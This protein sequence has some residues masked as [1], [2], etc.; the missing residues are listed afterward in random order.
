MVTEGV[1]TPKKGT[2]VKKH[3]T[4]S[5]SN[6]HSLEEA[7]LPVQI[8]IPLAEVLVNAE[9]AFFELCVQVGTQALEAMM[10][11]DRDAVCGPKGKHNPSRSALRSGSAPSEITLGGRRIGIRRLRARGSDGEISLPSFGHAAHRDPLDRHTMEAVAAGVSTR[12]YANTLEPLP[13]KTKER[14][15]SK[16][17]VSRRFIAL[18]QKKLAELLDVSLDGLDIRVIQIDGIAFRDHMVLIALGVDSSGNKQ[19][20]GIREGTTESSGVVHALL[21]N[22]IDRGLD[23]DRAR[24]F[25]IDGGKGIRSAIVK[26][27]GARAFIHRCHAHKQR[28][29]I[30][31]L[32]ESM[33]TRVAKVLTEAWH[34]SNV[35]TAKRRLESLA[36]SLDADHPG[37]ARSVR[38]G[39]EDTLTLQRLGVDVG[40]ALYKTLRTTN[41]IENL[42]GSIG[43]YTRN[44]K[45]WRG[46]SMVIRWVASA[47]LHAAEKFR[48]VRGYRELEALDHRL[49]MSDLVPFEAEQKSA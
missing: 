44:V 10:E 26:T 38:E 29:V 37:A 3:A 8:S 7:R 13:A 9:E 11:Q 6:V 4:P 2:A 41:P 40:G 5:P 27:F 16:S 23:P 49:R 33:R 39:L 45:R 24:V 46:G 17:T 42:N 18:S 1:T 48:R 36:G 30:E 43:T 20:L 19:V 21:R 22:L 12:N 35:E 25:V 14:S 47:V 32:P 15:V 28:N 31:H 34:S